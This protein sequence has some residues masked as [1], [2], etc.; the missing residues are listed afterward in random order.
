MHYNENGDRPQAETEEGVPLF[1]IS[2][3]KARKEECRVKPQKTQQT[4]GKGSNQTHIL[5]LKIY[6]DLDEESIKYIKKQ[7]LVFYKTGYVADMLDLLFEKVL[8]NPTPYTDA[9][10]AVPVPEDLSAQYEK[11]DK[12]VIARFVKFQTGGSLNPT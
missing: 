1:K 4:F 10:L 8:V 9:L 5:D 2:F 12:E 3:P 11:P 6:I 7:L